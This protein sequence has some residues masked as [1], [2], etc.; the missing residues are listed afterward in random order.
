MK[1]KLRTAIKLVLELLRTSEDKE[2]KN[3]L[4]QAHN[5]LMDVYQK[6]ERQLWRLKIISEMKFV[7]H[8]N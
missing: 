6:N 8:M 7:K 5:L 3:K 2:D 1:A 4:T